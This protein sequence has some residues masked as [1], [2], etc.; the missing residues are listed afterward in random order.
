MERERRIPEERTPEALPVQF[1]A[2][3]ERLRAV[4]N[5]VVWNYASIDGEWKK[6]PS[7]PITG[8]HASVRN[9]AS[10]G[11]FADAQQ[12]YGSG[13]FAGVGIV[14]TSDLGIVGVDIDHCIQDGELHPGAARIISLLDS[15]T[16]TSPS[17]AGIRILLE[18]KLPGVRR[19][20]GS[21]ELYEDLRYL[22]LTGQQREQTPQVIELR[23][24]AL[25]GVY[26]KL[27][28]EV[29]S[30]PAKENTGGGGGE[31]Q[32][33][34]ARALLPDETVLQKALQ[35]RNGET[36]RRYYTGDPS[37]WEGAGAK[38]R[39]QSEAD[40]TLALMLL[41]W[42]NGDAAQ[43]DRL[44]RQSGLMREKWNRASRGAE[45]YGERLIQDAISKGNH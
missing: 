11:S 19:R 29:T 16:E 33:T 43:V 28:P 1:D 30:R 4:D 9:P 8:R 13:Q 45:T 35:A 38:H 10:W 39:S 24:K 34:I 6:P 15:Y 17:G 20:R 14:L 21:I 2:L 7:S 23:H 44:F 41:Y 37:L 5:W 3:P 40:F 36:F 12:A 22:T 32:H 25:Y 27:F 18:G 42:T 26:H 31:Q